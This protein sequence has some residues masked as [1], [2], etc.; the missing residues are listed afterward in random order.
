MAADSEL[1]WSVWWPWVLLWALT[2]AA[3]VAA[4]VILV[5]HWRRSGRRPT[6][7]RVNDISFY[8]D[9]DS[10]MDI[11]R[12]QRY[13]PALRQQVEEKISSSKSAE[14]SA[15]SPV[16]KGGAKHNVNSEI[17]RKYIEKAE[18]IT[19]IGIILEVL[20]GADDIVHVDLGKSQIAHNKAMTKAL[21]PADGT[22]S[23]QRAPVGLSDL[24]AYVSLKGLF[25]KDTQN[26]EVTTF[27]AP[28]GSAADTD[29]AW[30][31]AECATSGLRRTVP[32]G[33]FQARCLGKVQDWDPRTR[34]LVIDP[35]AIFR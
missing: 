26:G 19:V 9:D 1:W 13:K 3:V 8:L 14:V 4:V 5:T 16:L 25:R 7:R 35:I 10:V 17:F 2:A 18:P 12:Q 28:Y 32:K 29:G 34:E 22:E 27:L 24:D 30:V 15:E 23:D 6:P 31:R 20:E 33:A 11:Y 21:D